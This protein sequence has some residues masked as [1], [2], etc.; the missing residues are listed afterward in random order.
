MKRLRQLHLYLGTF[1]APLLILFCVSG[2]IQILNIRGNLATHTLSNIHYGLGSL[3]KLKMSAD[4]IPLFSV[5]FQWFAAIMAAALILTIILGIIMAFRH[6]KSTPATISLT[7]G[8]VIPL[9]LII[10]AT[11]ALENLKDEKSKAV[12][13]HSVIDYSLN[14]SWKSLPWVVAA[15]YFLRITK[16]PKC[17]PS[18]R[19]FA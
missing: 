4:E 17:S 16:S 2:I 19:V 10:G 18:S 1:F 6:G 13:E 5:L 9:C 12:P 15:T 14:P 3:G 7:L 8:V 11:V